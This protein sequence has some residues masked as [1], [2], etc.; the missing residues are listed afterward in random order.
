MPYYL[1]FHFLAWF[2]EFYTC[3]QT[4]TQTQG[5]QQGYLILIGAEAQPDCTARR[6]EK[7]ESQCTP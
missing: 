6:V 4:Y 2:K 7:K 3:L 1:A 5:S